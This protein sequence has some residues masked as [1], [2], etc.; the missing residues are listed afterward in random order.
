MPRPA[1]PRAPVGPRARRQGARRAGTPTAPVPV[2]EELTACRVSA[3]HDPAGRR[4]GPV[5]AYVPGR[6]TSLTTTPHAAQTEQT[7]GP[8]SAR[9]PESASTTPSAI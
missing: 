8:A 3:R 1:P 9:R 2:A 6:L 4:A 5:E 7:A